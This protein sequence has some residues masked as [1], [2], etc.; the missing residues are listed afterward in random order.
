[1]AVKIGGVFSTFYDMIFGSMGKKKNID[2]LKM[3]GFDETTATQI[4]NIAENIRV[5]FENIGSTIGNIAGIVSNFVSDLLG[6]A[7]SK[8]GVNAIGS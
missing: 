5:T 6:I 4:V 1:L 2:F 7:G 3:I 8:Q